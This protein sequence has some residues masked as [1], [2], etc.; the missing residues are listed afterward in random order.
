[1]ITD[2]WGQAFLDQVLKTKPSESRTL[3]DQVVKDKPVI[4]TLGTGVQTGV[5]TAV[6]RPWGQVVKTSDQVSDS[7]WNTSA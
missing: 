2:P 4:K 7:K 6:I 1:L 3:G 5:R